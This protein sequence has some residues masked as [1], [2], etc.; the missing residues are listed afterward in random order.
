MRRAQ[1]A[2]AAETSNDVEQSFRGEALI[3]APRRWGRD[4]SGREVLFQVV[5]T[6]VWF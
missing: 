4:S 3:P 5:F 1:D 2:P 6:Y